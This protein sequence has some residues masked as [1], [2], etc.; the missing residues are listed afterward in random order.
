M[1]GWAKTIFVLGVFWLLTRWIG[2]GSFL[3]VDV[4]T[5]ALWAAVLLAFFL[6][7]RD[8]RA[9]LARLGLS[10]PETPLFI[11]EQRLARG[12]LDLDAYR[13][14]RDELLRPAGIPARNKNIKR[15]R[16]SRGG[17]HE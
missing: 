9:L 6:L 11:L 17:R 13:K 14:L 10:K 4:R 8:G 7:W 2:T 5:V 12:E 15:K 3:P 1:Q 16:V